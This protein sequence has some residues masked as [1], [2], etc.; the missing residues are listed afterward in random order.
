LY[1]IPGECLTLSATTF[2]SEN[3]QPQDIGV[4]GGGT[5]D[6]LKLAPQTT[7]SFCASA[8]NLPVENAA[9]VAETTQA[10]DQ[11]TRRSCD[12]A[13]APRVSSLLDFG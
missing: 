7:E 2:K 9:S 3:T 6:E 5:T 10:R 13:A 8:R 11:S 1:P 4:S 12:A